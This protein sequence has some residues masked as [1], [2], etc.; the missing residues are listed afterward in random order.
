VIEGGGPSGVRRTDA[1]NIEGGVPSGVRGT[2]AGN[3]GGGVPSGVRNSFP[4]ISSA[5]S[6][7]GG[8]SP[9]ELGPAAGA[10]TVGELG[11]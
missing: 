3:T 11:T 5:Q 9:T 6:D 8:V 2:D 4:N 10:A 7:T 1:G